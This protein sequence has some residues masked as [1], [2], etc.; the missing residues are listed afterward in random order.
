MGHSDIAPLRKVD[1]GEKFPWEYLAKKN[2][3]IWHNYNV[4]FLKRFRKEK[5]LNK[6]D[7]EKFFKSLNKIGYCFPN[8]NKQLLIK[9]IKAFQRHFRKELINGILDSECFI[10]AKNLVKK[11]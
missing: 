1:P 8:K 2:V 11:L 7:N 6:E 3:G 4:N 5:I 9:I 10:I